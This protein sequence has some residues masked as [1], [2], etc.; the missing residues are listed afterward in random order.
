[1]RWICL[2]IACALFAT[3]A[4]G[5]SKELSRA[6]DLY[7]SGQLTQARDHLRLLVDK[8]HF[9]TRDRIQARLYLAST[10][11]A[12]QEPAEA[13]E[14]LTILAR[15]HPNVR[16]DP[17]VFS[18]ELVVLSDQIRQEVAAQR[19]PRRGRD[20]A[21][22]KAELAQKAEAQRQAER[23]QKAE[24]Q[25][26]AEEARKAEAQRQ[27]EQARKA[28]VQRQAEEARKAEAQRQAELAQQSDAQRSEA[29]QPAPVKLLPSQTL[30]SGPLDTPPPP[31]EGHPGRRTWGYVAMGVGGAAAIVGALCGLAARSA[32]D[33]VAKAQ[34]HDEW[35]GARDR[36]DSN[37]KKATGSFVL[38]GLALTGGAV[39]V[40]TSF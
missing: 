37:G 39:M 5:R 7:E 2:V 20:E 32:A 23:A 40:A 29:R 6:V 13:R 27:A 25:R 4:W 34:T 28:E 19:T 31:S 9:S 26:Q 15:K 24:A 36:V 8:R 21:A 18:P 1:M 3:P 16:P 38:A 30:S 17:S 33:D 14:Q 12:L 35:A 22:Q 11:L 10:E